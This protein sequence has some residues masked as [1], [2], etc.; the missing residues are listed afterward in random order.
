ME[1]IDIH[2]AGP[3]EYDVAVV[4]SGATT[5]H[6]VQVPEQLRDSLGIPD[7]QAEERLVRESFA[8]LLER[9]PA[10]S[11]LDEF[12]LDAISR[13]FPEYDAEIEDRL[14]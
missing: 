8:F 6:R 10:T 9:E 12:G 7:D 3:H 11:I 5:T 2:R 1:R 14:A 13:Y 4:Q